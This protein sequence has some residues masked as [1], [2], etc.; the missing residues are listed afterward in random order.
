MYPVRVQ[1]VVWPVCCPG[2]CIWLH[3]ADMYFIALVW[4]VG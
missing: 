1:L 2:G 3:L 4:K